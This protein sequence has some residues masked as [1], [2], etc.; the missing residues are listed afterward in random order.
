ME[1]SGTFQYGKYVT[2]L[3]ASVQVT[4]GENGMYTKRTTHFVY[5]YK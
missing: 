4:L 5:E 2:L 3:Y 1:G